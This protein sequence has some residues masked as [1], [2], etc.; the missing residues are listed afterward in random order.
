MKQIKASAL[1]TV[2]EANKLMLLLQQAAQETNGSQSE[3]LR[4]A[5][6]N[7]ST[8]LGI[9]NEGIQTADPV[10]TRHGAQLLLQMAKYFLDVDLR[11]PDIEN[12]IES[13]LDKIH[14]A[15][16]PITTYIDE[17]NPENLVEARL[18]LQ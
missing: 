1:E 3:W 15:A 13:A 17:F 2:K 12:Q 4:M 18:A 16:L 14:A 5:S 8:Y 6:G 11:R 10:K 7:V 9:L